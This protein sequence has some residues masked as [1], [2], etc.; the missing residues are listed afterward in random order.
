MMINSRATWLA[1]LAAWGV[2]LFAAGCGDE[3]SNPISPSQDTVSIRGMVTDRLG[4]PLAGALV[5]VLG[6]PRAGIKTLTDGAGAIAVP[7]A[8]RNRMQS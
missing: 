3:A 8:L 4:Q 5:E 6:G 2:V 1:V 7:L